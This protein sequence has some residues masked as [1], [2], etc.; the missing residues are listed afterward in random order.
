M[1]LSKILLKIKFKSDHSIKSITLKYVK[2]E[3][4]TLLKSMQTFRV[5]NSNLLS[6]T[7]GGEIK[8]GSY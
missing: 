1:N 3:I 4:L 8:T 5:Q 6:T 7:I 2:K